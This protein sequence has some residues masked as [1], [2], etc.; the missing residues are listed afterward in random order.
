MRY[1]AFLMLT[2]ALSVVWPQSEWAHDRF[3]SFPDGVTVEG[4]WP[5]GPNVSRTGTP[6]FGV[7]EGN[8]GG[9]P[10]AY[11]RDLNI[12]RYYLGAESQG[13][14]PFVNDA[15]QV[16]YAAYT[17]QSHH[18]MV[19]GRD[20][21]AEVFPPNN[22]RNYNASV[23]GI[24]SFGRPFW[25]WRL[26]DGRYQVFRGTEEMS[27]GRDVWDALIY[28]VNRLGDCAWGAYVDTPGGKSLELFRNEVAYA[29]PI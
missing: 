2:L 10:Q 1:L 8:V 3:I 23:R 29:S 27:V 4:F 20:F 11:R 17:A 16:A 18:V 21:F 25:T 7:L 5:W 15:G 14:S 28:S 6:V 13:R 26:P 9:R 22:D 24:D 12:N 19:D